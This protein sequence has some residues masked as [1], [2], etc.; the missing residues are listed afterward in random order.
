MS[1]QQ[2][3]RTY[4]LAQIRTLFARPPGHTLL[5]WSLPAAFS[6]AADSASIDYLAPALCITENLGEKSGAY[7]KARRYKDFSFISIIIG[8]G[9]L[10]PQ[11]D[12]DSRQRRPAVWDERRK[13]GL[14]LCGTDYDEIEIQLKR[15]GPDEN[16][17][18]EAVY[19]NVFRSKIYPLQTPEDRENLIA[20]AGAL[21]RRIARRETVDLSAIKAEVKMLDPEEAGFGTLFNAYMTSSAVRK[22]I[23]DDR[24]SQGKGPFWED[25]KNGKITDMRELRLPLPR[26]Q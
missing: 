4:T 24:R 14:D 21:M 15:I 3:K 13:I 26:Y 18:Y 25:M 9:V 2:E 23:D 10:V 7:Y 8:S 11:E 1:E 22:L 16:D 19:I 5:T 6:Q 17:P 12:R 20:F